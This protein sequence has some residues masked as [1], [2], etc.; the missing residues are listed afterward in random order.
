MEELKIVYDF[1]DCFPRIGVMVFPL[2]FS[3]IGLGIF[4]YY[5]KG[6]I[7]DRTSMFGISRRKYGI[8][9][10]IFFASFGGLIS[11]ILISSNLLEYFKTKRVYQNKEYKIV[12]GRVEHY[13]PMPEGGHDSERFN[14]KG[15]MFQFSDYDLSNY[16]YNNAASKGGAIKENLLVRIAYFNN[17]ERN[18]ILKLET[19]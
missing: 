19:E 16:G 12:E 8:M 1:A 5:K 2:I 18:V 14:V 7:K 10:G 3:L 17:G 6:V 15:I 9:F 13:H 11:A 4:C